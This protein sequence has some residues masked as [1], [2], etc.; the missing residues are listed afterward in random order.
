VEERSRT[1]LRYAF[2]RCSERERHS[3]RV[4]GYF[5]IT[6]TVSREHGGY[7]VDEGKGSLSKAHALFSERNFDLIPL[8]T[9]ERF[10]RYISPEQRRPLAL[11]R[12]RYMEL[13]LHMFDT[14]LLPR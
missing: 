1:G 11:H 12:G 14:L 6:S 7:Q 8:G 3:D 4:P 10:A 13:P 2:T 9:Y 5:S